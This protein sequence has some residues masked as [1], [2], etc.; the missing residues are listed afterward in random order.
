MA[1]AKRA[2]SHS[3][4]AQA[5][6]LRAKRRGQAKRT[7]QAGRLAVA[8]GLGFAVATGHGVAT[9]ATDD[10]Q[11]AGDSSDTD[12]GTTTND[13]GTTSSGTTTETETE[14]PNT[15][16]DGSQTATTTSGDG[17]TTSTSSSG[18][19][20]TS[21]EYQEEDE[22]ESAGVETGG[23]AGTTPAEPAAGAEVENPPAATDP[24]AAQ[25]EVTE[26]AA[27]EVTEAVVTEPVTE[28]PTGEVMALSAVD[29][30]GEEP[31][32]EEITVP[33]EA[34]SMATTTTLQAVELP[35]YPTVP[36][37]T[38]TQVAVAVVVVLFR[39]LQ[40][41]MSG[42]VPNPVAIPLYLILVAAYQRLT[43][44][45]LNHVPVATPSTPLVVPITNTVTGFLNASDPDGDPLSW[46]VTGDPAKGSVILD[47]VLGSYVYTPKL[48]FIRDGGTDT[49]TVT[50]DDSAGAAEHFYAP[51]GHTTTTDITITLAGTGIN[52]API[53]TATPGPRDDIGVIR[54]GVG[55]VD[56]DDETH[57]FSLANGNTAGATA[58]STYTN[59]GGIVSLDT[60]T[61]DWTYV[62]AV[63]GNLLG[64]PLNTDSFVV[65]TT[66]G[67]GTSVQTTVLVGADLQIA[68]TGTSTNPSNGAYSGGLN[69]PEADEGLLTYSGGTV[70]PAKG[71]L[72]VDE[73][74][75][76]TYTPTAAARHAAA[77]DNAT[78]AQKVH[79]FDIYGTD[80]NNRTI[81]VATVEVTISSTNSLP[82]ATYSLNPAD[83]NG[84][85]T[86]TISVTDGDLTDDHTFGQ[87]TIFTGKGTVTVNTDTGAF[88]FT[89]TT[90]ARHA[91][92]ATNAS[93]SDKEVSFSINVNDGYG[94][95]TTVSVTAPVS[96]KNT[97]PTVSYTRVAVAGIVTY[98]P[99]V[100][101]PDLDVV[102][103]TIT[104]QP[105]KGTV[106]IN[107]GGAIVYTANNLLFP[108]A[109]SFVVTASDGHGGVIVT[110]LNPY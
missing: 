80:A 83:A 41:A 63:S 27:P 32:E 85:V 110:T 2:H 38:P 54:G 44:I 35:E 14:T 66:D 64:I 33:V 92:A 96:P 81:K 109:D 56:V 55:V 9:A 16:T 40:G 102:T 103:H 42:P 99:V 104:T 94:G 51:N 29:T 19:A 46:S 98:T 6:R 37:A 20:L 4:R 24:E 13:S 31:A 3:K 53:V 11:S 28:E 39:A 107:L 86:G 43:Q 101:D 76:F 79:T 36:G 89:P 1:A 68:P 45:A 26:G 69:I 90:T 47:P 12:T 100:T 59:L 57:T 78:S 71:T 23:E 5:K 77:L 67:F 73:N 8:V 91:A 15:A 48:S 95:T 75:N 18:G 49:F 108:Q 70:D 93:E 82:S 72:T 30:S 87:A 74:G 105:T 58:T 61:G 10:G 21:A 106:L 62:P 17:P 50:I 88:T 34:R 84:V 65:T 52:V 60:A 97:A 25:A 22:A 7:Q